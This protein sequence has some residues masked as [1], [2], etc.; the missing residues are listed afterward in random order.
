MQ[1]CPVS[2]IANIGRFCYS[3]VYGFSMSSSFLPI[4]IIP[5]YYTRSKRLILSRR[6]CKRQG[7]YPSCAK[8]SKSSFKKTALDKEIESV[9]ESFSWRGNRCKKFLKNIKSAGRRRNIRSEECFAGRSLKTTNTKKMGNDLVLEGGCD[10]PDAKSGEGSQG[11]AGKRILEEFK[12]FLKAKAGLEIVA[13]EVVLEAIIQKG[14]NNLGAETKIYVSD[15]LK[16]IELK[17]RLGPQTSDAIQ[18]KIDK[19]L[20]TKPTDKKEEK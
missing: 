4:Y 9:V 8:F 17:Q 1:T 2:V 7:R 3:I 20:N 5:M 6:K 19:L 11:D 16:A 12:A 18:D 14:F 10:A 13:T 15:I